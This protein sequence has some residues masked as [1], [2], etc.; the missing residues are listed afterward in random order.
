[1]STPDNQSPVMAEYNTPD[2]TIGDRLQ[3]LREEKGLSIQ[4]VSKETHISSTNLLAIEGENFD[5]LP[6]DTFIRG[7]ITIY[8]NFLGIDGAEA[9]RL[10]LQ[11][12]NQRQPRGKKNRPGKAGHSLAPKKLA[13]PSHVSS[14]TIA[15]ILLLLIVA[16]FTAVC[17]YTGWNPFAYFL[18]QG[19]P[20][21]PPVTGT[22]TSGIQDT[23]TGTAASSETKSA[24]PS[25]TQVRESTKKNIQKNATG[26]DAGKTALPYTLTAVF[27]RNTG[28]EIVIDDQDP[29]RLQGKKDEQQQWQAAKS[30]QLRFEHPDSATIMVNGVTIAFPTVMRDGKPT[31]TIPDALPGR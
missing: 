5:Q 19:Q 14:A 27:T 7:Q 26:S 28:V 11:E 10:F 1:M 16:S 17:L 23:E 15:G 9:A 8:G 6:A 29:V 25:T 2:T 21:M 12:R 22:V 20:T 18:N 4:E 3:Q 13:E 30:M 31:L 24:A